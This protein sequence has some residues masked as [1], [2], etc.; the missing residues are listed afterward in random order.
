[1]KRAAVT[2]RYSANGLLGQLTL[3]LG[4]VQVCG[5]PPAL[6]EWAAA[7]HWKAHPEDTPTA[8]TVVQLHDVAGDDFGLFE[9][10]CEQRL[11]FTASPLRQA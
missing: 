4:V 3:P 6:A 5:G 1:M 7:D 2:I 8:I 11:I 10:R 9:V